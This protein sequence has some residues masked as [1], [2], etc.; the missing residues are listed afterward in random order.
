MFKFFRKIRYTLLNDGKLRRYSVYAIGEILLIVIGIWIALML[1]EWKRNINQNTIEIKLLSELHDDLKETEKLFSSN[2][3]M[4]YRIME[5]KRVIIDVIEYKMPWHDSLQ[6]HFNLFNFWNTYSIK[7]AAYNSIEN[8][9]INNISNDSLRRQLS[10][11]YQNEVHDLD[12]SERL[13]RHVQVSSLNDI[14]S[15][16]LDWGDINRVRPVNYESFLKNREFE[17]RLKAFMTFSQLG[18]N[19]KRALLEKIRTVKRN[20]FEELERKMKY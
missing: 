10:N 16:N 7:S 11:M 9:G 6:G 8:W 2:L 13:E 20:V 4:D 3:K 17:M 12:E 19:N 5:S 15:T 18:I 14:I 1:N